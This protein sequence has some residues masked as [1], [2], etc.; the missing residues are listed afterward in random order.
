MPRTNYGYPF[1][2]KV[3]RFARQLSKRFTSGAEPRS[4]LLRFDRE[5]NVV[6]LVFEDGESSWYGQHRELEKAGV[7]HLFFNPLDD[8]DFRWVCLSWHEI[9]QSVMER[10]LGEAF[11]S[12]DFEPIP[13]PAERSGQLDQASFPSCWYTEA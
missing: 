10:L 4:F 5:G 8:G 7:P 3:G 2:S 11:T 6:S 9:E 12:L 1:E 13:S